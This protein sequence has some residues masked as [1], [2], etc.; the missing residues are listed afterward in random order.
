[1]A[2][3]FKMTFDAHLVFN[4]FFPKVNQII[5]HIQRTTPS[6]LNAIQPIFHKISR[7]QVFGLPFFQNVLDDFFPKVY[8]IIR[9]T[10][11]T[12]KS[13]LNAIQ[14][15]VHKISR[16]HKL[17]G[18]S[19]YT[20]KQVAVSEEPVPIV[21]NMAVGCFLFNLFKLCHLFLA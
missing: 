17:F 18:R 7:P 8:Q 13:N 3:F 14:P 11:Q 20:M 1:M 10:Q 15:T 5:R 2:I 12:R 6:N 19:L 4:G 16:A 9:N 21:F